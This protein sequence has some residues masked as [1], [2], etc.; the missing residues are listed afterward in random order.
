MLNQASDRYRIAIF[1][2]DNDK[3]LNARNWSVGISIRKWVFIL[4]D[5]ANAHKDV[6]DNTASSVIPNEMLVV[7]AESSL[8][9]KT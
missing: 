2:D 1:S 4:K 6:I 3:L 5:D 9:Q 8:N 7:E